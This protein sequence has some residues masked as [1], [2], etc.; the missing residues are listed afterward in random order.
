[1]C[2][3]HN[4]LGVGVGIQCGKCGK[5]GMPV[6]G[7][8]YYCDSCH[9]SWENTDRQTRDVQ[10]C[11]FVHRVGAG[12]SIRVFKLEGGGEACGVVCLDCGAVG[13]IAGSVDEAV[14]KWNERLMLVV[15]REQYE[16]MK[17]GR[18]EEREVA[19]GVKGGR[20]GN[21]EEDRQVDAEAPV[22]EKVVKGCA[23][24]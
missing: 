2:C 16:E 22:G 4:S 18:E 7:D 21:A 11:P 9:F 19:N 10:K 12:M 8:E 14:R 20:E 13:P 3:Y 5:V 1:M 15:S 17:R 23:E 6:G 24:V